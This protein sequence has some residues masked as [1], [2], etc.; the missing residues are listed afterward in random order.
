MTEEVGDGA[1]IGEE[2]MEQR[3]MERLLR[4]ITEAGPGTVSWRNRWR[5]VSEEE[6]TRRGGGSP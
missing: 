1:R 5:Q 4:R 3:I 6:G 2:A